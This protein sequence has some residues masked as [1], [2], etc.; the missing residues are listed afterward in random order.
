MKAVT[1]LQ[2][3]EVFVKL[4]AAK[5]HLE[6]KCKKQ[7]K[8]FGRAVLTVCASH[9]NLSFFSFTFTQNTFVSA[10]R[11]ILFFFPYFCGLGQVTRQSVPTTVD[12]ISLPIIVYKRC[13]KLPTP[14]TK[15]RS[16]ELRA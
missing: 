2:T 12:G 1:Y 5:L 13:N 7:V 3:Q 16:K 9:S 8:K 11:F 6:R 15:T 14:L 4:L 10:T